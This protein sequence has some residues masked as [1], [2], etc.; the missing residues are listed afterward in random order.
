MSIPP[1]AR[2]GRRV[3]AAVALLSLTVAGCAEPERPVERA[4]SPP[5]GQP[6]PT[7]R[8]EIAAHEG[9]V[10]PE[11]LPRTQENHGFGTDQPAESAPTLLTPEEAWVCRYDPTDTPTD[12]SADG[13]SF[14]WV[15]ADDPKGV[16]AALLPELAQAISDLVPAPLHQACTDDLGSRFMLVYVH[17]RDLTGVVADDYGCRAVRL[18]DEPGETVPGMSTS[19]G[20]VPGALA[21][22]PTLLQQ[23]EAS[24]AGVSGEPVSF[25]PDG[26]GAL[27][28][29]MTRAEVAATGLASTLRGSG[30]D[31]W[32]P[33]CFVLEYRSDRL[34]R[35]PGD[36]LNGTLSSDEGLETLYATYAMVTPQ[37]IRLGSPVEE[38]RRAYDRPGVEPVDQIE[39][40]A[41]EAVLY[42]IVVDE[43]VVTSMQLE[44]RRPKCTR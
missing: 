3:L 14:A 38:V 17:G 39:V 32:P 44:L 27:R 6:T 18:T 15:R 19:E 40:R 20:V 9:E 2:P 30:H 33:G 21:A 1:R 7:P 29:G 24:Y 41:A 35:T 26:A 36:S 28:L 10:C 42:R 37:G 22:D 25:G 16:D 4:T 43:A 34:G 23:L 5:V 13:A 12:T 11:V 8:D 31:G